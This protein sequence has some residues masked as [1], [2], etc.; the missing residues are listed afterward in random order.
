MRAIW[1]GALAFG[2]VSIPVRL[3]SAT[4]DRDVSFHQVHEEDAGR[5]RYQRVCTVCGEEVPYADL[6]KG[7]ELPS[8]ETVMLTE[9]DFANLPLPTTKIVELAA[10]V[11]S[12]QVDPLALSRGYYLEPEPAS[13][14]PYELLR[15]AL[16]RT[17]RVGLAKIALRSKESLAVLR[18]RGGALA[19]Q[20]MVWPD[21]VRKAQFDVLDREVS[22]SDAELRMA[23]TL[24][25]AMASDFAPEAYQ[26]GYRE[27]LLSVIEAKTTGRDVTARPEPSEPTP[28]MDLIT[29]L[30]AS[31]EAAKAARGERVSVPKQRKPPDTSDKRTHRR[32]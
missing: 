29:A 13:R 23:D 28:S 1:K 22:V 9:E 18:P 12:D 2:M 5:V 8:G 19:L 26:D 10:F 6:A 17:Q 31:V 24:I 14:K 4:E 27:A 32:R 3:Y 11:P 30:Q 20:T 15:A 21:E 25:E 16:E 7:F